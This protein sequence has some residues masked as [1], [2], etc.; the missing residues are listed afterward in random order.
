V[1]LQ[2]RELAR[3]ESPIWGDASSVSFAD[4][5]S[6]ALRGGKALGDDGSEPIALTVTPGGDGELE[7]EYRPAT[8][9]E[10][11]TGLLS[12]LAWLVTLALLL[13]RCP[14]WLE[15]KLLTPLRVRAPDFDRLLSSRVHLVGALVGLLLLG[16]GWTRGA[17]KQEG[18]LAS[19]EWK[20]ANAEGRPVGEF[21]PLKT[22]MLIRPAL[23][24]LISETKPVD[25]HLAD[26]PCDQPLQGWIS[27]DDDWAKQRERS[28]FSLTLDAGEKPVELVS[29][30][31]GPGRQTF[32]VPAQSCNDGQLRLRLQSVGKGTHTLGLWLQ[33]GADK[34]G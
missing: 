30:R 14:Q 8:T 21:G 15:T 31:H 1:T 11:I 16:A 25:V 4:R 20:A 2:G 7:L 12:F 34:V 26:L 13:P 10:R 6:G 9:P 19:W 28:R 5:R 27:L 17:A 33:A 24:V 22:D 23:R 3:S 18:S 32:R 29:F